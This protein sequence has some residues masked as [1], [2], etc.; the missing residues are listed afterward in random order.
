MGL[1][2]ESIGFL[3]RE[4]YKRQSGI[5]CLAVLSPNL[6]RAKVQAGANSSGAMISPA[7]VPGWLQVGPTHGRAKPAAHELMLL[8]V[9]PACPGGPGSFQAVHNKAT[10]YCGQVPLPHVSLVCD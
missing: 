4:V 1:S 3:R 5:D 9:L 8:Q 2:E 10:L 7:W 6:R